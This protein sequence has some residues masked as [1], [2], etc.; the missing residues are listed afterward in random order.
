VSSPIIILNKIT[1][2]KVNEIK[3]VKNL[4]IDMKQLKK[5]IINAKKNNL[6]NL[7]SRS[8]LS[9]L[10]NNSYIEFK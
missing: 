2:L 1:F 9:K 4:D 8:H 6:L 5:N 10:K 3:I 7:Y